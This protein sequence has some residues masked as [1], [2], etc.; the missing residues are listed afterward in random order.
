MSE[1]SE[2]DK[3]AILGQGRTP[4]ELIEA[5][6]VSIKTP[7]KRLASCESQK[8]TAVFIV[9]TGLAL[10]IGGYVLNGSTLGFEKGLAALFIAGG[11]VWYIYLSIT[12]KRLRADG[13]QP[14]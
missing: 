12:A 10:A 1:L 14:E 11:I 5:L 13:V 8:M 6:Q 7:G 4:N 9:I 2:R 3:Q